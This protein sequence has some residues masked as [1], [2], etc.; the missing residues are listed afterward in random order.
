MSNLIPVGTSI[1]IDG[2]NRC[3]LFT[4]SAIHEIQ[5]EFGKPLESVINEVMEP[6]RNIIDTM[7]WVKAMLTIMF[8]DEARRNQK[9][10]TKVENVHFNDILTTKN[11]WE[12][13]MIIL[14]EYGVDIPEPD[15]DD[16]NQ[17][18]E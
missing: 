16:P 10:E 12:I 11:T 3:I 6:E 8:N 13:V 2:E 9:P 14:R 18:G 7:N 4:L 17:K 1:N 15:E 5:E